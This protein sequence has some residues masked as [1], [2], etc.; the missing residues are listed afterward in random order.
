MLG[1][2]ILKYFLN[3]LM[4]MCCAFTADVRE[5]ECKTFIN[6]TPSKSDLQDTKIMFSLISAPVSRPDKRWL[7]ENT[8]LLPFYKVIE[9]LV[10]LWEKSEKRGIDL[11]TRFLFLVLPN[12]H[13]FFWTGTWNLFSFSPG[14]DNT[15][16]IGTGT[17]EV[18]GIAW[19]RA[20]GS[21]A[22][23]SCMGFDTFFRVLVSS[24]TKNFE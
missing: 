10:R 17:I 12:L 3:H 20:W 6:D 22:H 1:E 8:W 13:V 16:C 14:K 4:L 15:G 2:F 5:W 21:F 7:L 23:L 24:V 19:L 11:R 18:N 9:P